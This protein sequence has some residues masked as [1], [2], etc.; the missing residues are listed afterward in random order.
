MGQF[1]SIAVGRI[2]GSVSVV[3]G[4][5]DIVAV[6]VFIGEDRDGASDHGVGRECAEIA[7]V[8]T[9]GMAWIQEEE[10][11]LGDD[12]AALPNGQVASEAVERLGL[13]QGDVVDS[14]SD[15]V[16]ADTL[17]GKRGDMLEERHAFR[18]IAALVEIDRE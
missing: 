3:I 4:A 16:T 11:R 14:D 9:V 5:P 2:F 18:Q 7:T 15:V 13:R 8:E 12:V 10:F 17:S 1:L 6:A